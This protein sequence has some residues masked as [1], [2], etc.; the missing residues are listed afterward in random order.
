MGRD[1][2]NRGQTALLFWFGCVAMGGVA[3]ASGDSPPATEAGGAQVGTASAPSTSGAGGSAEEQAPAFK[4]MSLEELMNVEVATVTTASKAPEKTTDAP[5]TVLVVTANDVKLR[6][7][8]NLKDVLR[9]LPGMDTT[10]N[11]FSEI[12]TLVPVRGIVGNNLIVVLVNGMRVNPPG[13]EYFPLRSDFSVRDVEQIEVIY[14]PGSTLY[15]QDAISAVINVKTKK[16]VQGQSGELVLDGGLYSEREGFISFDKI[17]QKQNF[18]LS[19]YFQYHDSDL[20]PIN[21]DYPDF[22]RDYATYSRTETPR[23]LGDPPIRRDFGLNGFARVEGDNWSI[24]GWY[25]QSER[26]SAEAKVPEQSGYL[27]KAKWGDS[28]LVLEARDKIPFSDTLSLESAFSY[29]RYEIEPSSRYVNPGSGNPN[30]PGHWFFTDNKYGIGKG[31]TLEEDLRWQ[32]TPKI[33]LL[34]G[35]YAGAFDIIPKNTIPGGGKRKWQH[36]RPGRRSQ[37]TL[38]HDKRYNTVPSEQS[39]E[40]RDH[41][42][43]GDAGSLPDLCRLS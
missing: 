10:E 40:S 8:S 23:G 38:L 11:Y 2:G 20:N 27:D 41:D 3:T 4:K 26:S 35:G 33:S 19:G 28:S 14:G 25:R 7:Y 9:D 15:G 34:L 31:Y 22:F 17:F 5:A 42:L 32:A 12:G 18:S 36:R 37:C 21:S 24:Q 1:S 39:R 30:T 6:G 43:T 16:P 13:G 29:N